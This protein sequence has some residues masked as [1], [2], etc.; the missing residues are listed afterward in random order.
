MSQLRVKCE[1]LRVSKVGPLY[2]TKRTST[3]GVAT[4]LMGHEQS[5][6]RSWETN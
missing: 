3:K 4:S 5:F 2:P 1:E 6:S